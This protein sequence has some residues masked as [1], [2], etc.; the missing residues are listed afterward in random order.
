M[1]TENVIQPQILEK[2]LLLKEMK[3]YIQKNIQ[4]M[5]KIQEKCV[6]DSNLHVFFTEYKEKYELLNKTF[7]AEV[8]KKIKSECPHV[9]EEDYIDMYVG[10]V[11]VCQKITYCLMCESTFPQK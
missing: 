10:C 11:E 5:D 8:D 3:N 6:N 4:K 1:S 9:Y 2:I 7:R